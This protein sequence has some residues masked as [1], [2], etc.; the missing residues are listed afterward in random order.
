MCLLVNELFVKLGSKLFNVIV[1]LDVIMSSVVYQ[2]VTVFFIA[3]IIIVLLPIHA[4]ASPVT[5]I[6]VTG[7]AHILSLTGANDFRL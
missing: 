4:R 7:C 1:L 6:L 2:L 5:S 3:L